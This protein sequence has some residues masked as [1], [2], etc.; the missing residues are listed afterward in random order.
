MQQQQQLAGVAGWWG[1]AAGWDPVRSA[2]TA[3]GR[4]RHG[5]AHVPSL[6]ESLPA[7]LCAGLLGSGLA[8]AE[9]L[10]AMTGM[11]SRRRVHPPKTPRTRPKILA[12]AMPLAPCHAMPCQSHHQ[13]P[14]HH[15]H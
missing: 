11:G 4:A 12:R 15:Q 10:G 1:G 6:Q 9:R 5:V 8:L 2:A 13:S 7:S 14:S 3:L